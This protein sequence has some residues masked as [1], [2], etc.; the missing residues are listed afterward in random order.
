MEKV[1]RKGEEGSE[2]SRVE[3]FSGAGTVTLNARRLRR[4][5]SVKEIGTREGVRRGAGSPTMPAPG[6]TGEDRG[7][8]KCGL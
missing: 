2:M 8:R 5:S 7:G 4:A 6:R 3:P 1:E